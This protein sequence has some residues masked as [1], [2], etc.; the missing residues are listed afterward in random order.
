MLFFEIN[1]QK[2]ESGLFIFFEIFSVFHFSVLF[3]CSKTKKNQF[4]QA[5]ISILMIKLLCFNVLYSCGIRVHDDESDDPTTQ[6][7]L[8]AIPILPT[9]NGP[10][11]NST[12]ALIENR[13]I[14]ENRNISWV[15]SSFILYLL[16]MIPT[17]EFEIWNTK[18]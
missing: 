14:L 9:S 1:P 8:L 2:N 18:K 17:S 16:W 12:S 7:P 5:N 11:N 6:K 4:F 15:K 10:V 13:T 3:K